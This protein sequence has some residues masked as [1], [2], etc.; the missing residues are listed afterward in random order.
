MIDTLYTLKT[1]Y[2]NKKIYIWNVNRNSIMVF[3]EAILRGIDI[4]GF[5]V[6]HK[7]LIGEEYINRPVVTWDE[8]ACEEDRLLLLSDEVAKDKI[9]IPVNDKMIYWTDSLAFN[10]KLRHRKIIIYGIGWGANQLDKILS[11]ECVKAQLYCVTKK[12]Y[13]QQQH[14]GKKIIEVNELSEYEDYAIIV[15]VVEGKYRQEIFESLLKFRGQIYVEHIIG[16]LENAHINLIQSIDKAIK[17]QKKIYMYSTRNI[18]SESIEQVLAIYGVKISGYVHNIEDKDQNIKSIYE[19]ALDGIEDKMIIL[20]EECPEKMIQAREV[21]EFAGFSLEKGDYTGLQ[22]YTR[23]KESLLNEL[24]NCYDPLVGYSNSFFMEK[25]GSKLYGKPGW[26]IYGQENRK[27]IRILVLGGSTS[28]EVWH[29]ENWVSKLYYK[30]RKE[31][32]EVVIY[33]GAYEGNDIVDE[34]LRL[35][36]DAHALCPQIVISMS[37]VNNTYYKR[38]DSQFN[39]ENLVDWVHRFAAGEK[40]CSGLY[41]DEPL[42]EFWNRNINLLKIIS[43]FYGAVFFGFLQP[44]NITMSDMSVWEK[45]VYELEEHMEGVKSFAGFSGESNTYVNLMRLFEHQDEM[46][47][48]MCHYTDK[49]HKIIAERVLEVI[50]PAL[51]RLKAKE[52]L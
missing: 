28:A 50:K 11:K 10:E 30:L 44:M 52:Q 47:F 8:I 38:S 45:S 40:Y 25:S 39:E 32:M 33:N 51:L 7:Q 43:E 19:L 5:V 14:K 31:M 18:F 3:A 49:G 16:E 42:Y 29:P 21:I 20:N 26:K 46:Y 23:A 13:G 15:S 41:D 24:S 37:G 9:G 36:R 6:L 48:D 17:K 4:Q 34:I 2:R 27:K 12:E 22:W 35:L 1:E